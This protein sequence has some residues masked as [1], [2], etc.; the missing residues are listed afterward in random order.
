[1]TVVVNA[2]LAPCLVLGSGWFPALGV[3]GAGWAT[4]I[5]ASLNAWM[6]LVGLIDRTTATA[7]L[8]PLLVLSARWASHSYSDDGHLLVQRAVP[9]SE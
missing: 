9:A 7:V 3:S 4:L 6:S 2:A 8:A 5:A 1:M